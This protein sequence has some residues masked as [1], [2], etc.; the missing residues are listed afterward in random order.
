[1]EPAVNPVYGSQSMPHA[2]YSG[3][4]GND[5]YGNCCNL[6]GYVRTHHTGRH[7]R[8]MTMYDN[9]TMHLKSASHNY[10]E[11]A[12]C[13]TPR[14]TVQLPLPVHGQVS[15]FCIQPVERAEQV[16]SSWLCDMHVDHRGCDPLMA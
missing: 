4:W 7:V 14:Q 8:P 9:V 1:M 13:Q 15:S 16:G 12:S 11:N 3:I 10:L 6:S 2:V 5:G